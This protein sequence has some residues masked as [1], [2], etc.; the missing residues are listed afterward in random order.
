M[1]NAGYPIG[2]LHLLL[3][4]CIYNICKKYNN[5]IQCFIKEL[6]NASFY[7]IRKCFNVK[8]NLGW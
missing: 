5:S 2:Q 1:K 8:K 6:I 3:M 4:K 7:V